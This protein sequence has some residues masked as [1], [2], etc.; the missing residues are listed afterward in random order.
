MNH[1]VLFGLLLFCHSSL[2]VGWEPLDEESS[3]SEKK[4][5]RDEES[6]CEESIVIQEG[7]ERK[8][9]L[10]ISLELP[11]FLAD[12]TEEEIRKAIADYD[13]REKK[14]AK[15]AKLVWDVAKRVPLAIVDPIST[16]L[17]E[18]I[19][20]TTGK[21]MKKIKHSRMGQEAAM[22]TVSKDRH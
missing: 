6:S 13:K 3:I 18:V 12:A 4:S 20:I 2:A 14:K 21:I 17:W 11:F 15:G 7:K 9:K 8:V 22:G 19:D 5:I 10:P 16:I 1:L